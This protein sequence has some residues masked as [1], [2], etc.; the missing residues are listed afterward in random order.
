MTENTYFCAVRH[1]TQLIL[2]FRIWISRLVHRR[3][4]GVQSPFAYNLICNVVNEKGMYYSYEHLQQA[5]MKKPKSELRNNL[6]SDKLLFRLANYIQPAI[7]IFPEEGF[8]MS[9]CYAMSGCKAARTVSYNDWHELLQLTE[10]GI[11]TELLYIRGDVC[12]EKTLLDIIPQ[13]HEHSL[14]IVENIYK[15]KKAKHLWHI[16]IESSSAILTFDLY[17]CGL[18]LF[19]RKYVKQH[20]IASF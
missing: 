12:D 6:K 16:L 14:L 17:S 5:R 2:D 18:V 13:M 10:W 15:N 7:M 19:N 9:K 4:F 3:G 20:Y 1:K 11:Q 8:S